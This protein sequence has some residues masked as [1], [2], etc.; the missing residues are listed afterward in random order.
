MTPAMTEVAAPEAMTPETARRIRAEL[1]GDLY[2]INKRTRYMPLL[3]MLALDA[4]QWAF[5]P[6]AALV[7]VTLAYLAGVAAFDI[8]RAAYHRAKPGVE[9]AARWGWIYG[10]VSF[11]TGSC[12][13][14]LAA[15]AFPIDQ[16]IADFI[17]LLS[18]ALMVSA[19]ATT[20]GYFLPAHYLFMAGAGW[21]LIALLIWMNDSTGYLILGIIGVYFY[22]MMRWGAGQF[23]TYFSTGVLRHRHDHLIG[24]LRQAL[25]KAEAAAVAKSRFLANVSHEIRT[26]AHGVLATLELLDRGGQTGEARER[27]LGMARN[28]ANALLLLIED[29]LDFSRV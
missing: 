13:G 8:V 20:R 25:G 2:A 26:P 4:L 3:V 16:P 6:Q 24:E 27:L 14:S 9:D 1:I 18:V 29:V 19:S 17:V 28:S 10:A 5:A 15:I 22:S 23:G 12:W 11:W 21:P 7:G